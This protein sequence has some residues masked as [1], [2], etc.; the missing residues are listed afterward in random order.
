M[1]FDPR[2]SIDQGLAE[3]ASLPS[4]RRPM[5]AER[6]AKT[7][8]RWTIWNFAISA[9]FFGTAAFLM[10]LEP[11]LFPVSA[12]ALIHGFSIP[13]LYARRGA[14][15]IVP[16]GG[17]GS[18]A[19][20]GEA[21]AEGVALG[22]LGDLVGHEARELARETGLVM[23]RG[24]LGVWLLGERGAILV[25]PGGKRVVC[26]CVKI[27]DVEGLPAADRISHLLLALRE[28]EL[29]FATIANLDFSGA[30][31]RL[32]PRLERR[33]RPALERAVE[34]AVEP[35]GTGAGQASTEALPAHS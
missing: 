7:E 16:L 18:A 32:R 23:S 15:S 8:R 2:E 24:K 13:M 6:L 17:I 21:R 31:R 10:Y 3:V 34:A 20:K 28:D 11:L 19:G 27:A 12:W 35:P 5:T 14:R 22:L 25:R 9:P 26:W 4:W 30:T 33:A 29:G 1:R